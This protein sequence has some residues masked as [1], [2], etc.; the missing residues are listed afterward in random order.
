M[1]EQKY[2]KLSEYARENS[3]TYRTAWNR[4]K[5]D[6][7]KGAF[8]DNT[9]HVLIPLFPEINSA[10]NA[11]LY[12]RVSNND[13]KKELEYQLERIRNY[14]INN[15]YKIIDEIKEIASGM[16]DD[17][18]KLNKILVRKDW[19]VIIVENKDRL[20]RFGFNYLNLLLKLNGKQ[21]VVINNSNEDK[22]DLINDL[23]SIIYSFSARLYGL[24]KRKNKEDV[25]NFLKQ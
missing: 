20:T 1:R 7:I 5:S 18:P 16:N 11:I 12:A 19:D 15:G 3:V 25:I 10:T 17:R 22:Q 14:S 24:R 6:K 4:F 2:K 9:N 13:R 8:L 21:I 23:V